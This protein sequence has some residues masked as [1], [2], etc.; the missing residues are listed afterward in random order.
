[1]RKN[2][3]KGALVPLIMTIVICSLTILFTKDS[4]QKLSEGLETQ[5]AKGRSYEPKRAGYAIV[6]IINIEETDIKDEKLSDGEKFYLVEHDKGTT[7]LKATPDDAKR[8]LGESFTKDKKLYNIG[9]NPIY[10]KIDGVPSKTGKGNK[11][12]SVPDELQ[13]KFEEAYST[14]DIN[15]KRLKRIA[16]D[17]EKGVDTTTIKN[18]EKERPLFLDVYIEPLSRYYHL[19]QLIG[20]TIAI[21]ISLWMIKVV[22]RRIRINKES[23]KRLFVSY[24]ETKRDLDII[25]RE[26][27]FFNKEFKVLIY[28][29]MFISY[30]AEFIALYISDIKSIKVN[31][32][33]GRGRRKFYHMIIKSTKDGVHKVPFPENA[34]KEQLKIFINT[35]RDSF[36]INV[37]LTF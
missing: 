3:L 15:S 21:L 28:K 19:S 24:P 33:Y 8:M 20:S 11:K 12:I 25:L 6:K 17:Y 22:Y 4:I 5:Y 26:A 27:K 34:T 37:K 18:R 13:K 16:V 23:Y 29:D 9:D 36:G 2:Y 10:A 7:M 30:G 35:L 32:A 31:S 14:S 1:M